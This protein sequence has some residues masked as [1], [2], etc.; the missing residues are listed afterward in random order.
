MP[1]LKQGVDP[2]QEKIASLLEYRQSPTFEEAVETFLE[3]VKVDNKARTLKEYERILR[4]DFIPDLGRMKIADVKRKQVVA[5]LDEKVK[6][7]P[8]QA[9][10]R[11]GD[12]G[13]R[14]GIGCPSLP[15]EG[16]LAT[17]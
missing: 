9:N 10:R 4:K 6:T 8:V 16:W 11:P 2:G 5:L 12:H 14:P 7:S 15:G 3:Y 13:H 17:E 1:T